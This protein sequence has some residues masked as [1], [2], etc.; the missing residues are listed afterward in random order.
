M[1]NQNETPKKEKK[2][3]L[4]SMKAELRNEK[5]EA[6]KERGGLWRTVIG[7]VKKYKTQAK[8]SLLVRSKRTEKWHKQAAEWPLKFLAKIDRLERVAGDMTAIQAKTIGHGYD[9][10][11]TVVTKVDDIADE[12]LTR[13][14]SRCA[15]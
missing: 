14:E 5:T 7:K 2:A 13:A 15:A 11:R 12:V 9:L 8:T 3:S 4:K 1:A 10:M 6:P